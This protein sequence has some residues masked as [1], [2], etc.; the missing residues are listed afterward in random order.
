MIDEPDIALHMPYLE[1]VAFHSPFI[2]ELG[3][4]DG[5]GSTRAFQRGHERYGA[6]LGE[7][8]GRIHV[9]VELRADRPKCAYNSR[10]WWLLTG[11]SISPE[12]FT[13]LRIAYCMPADLIF[14]DTE[15]TYEHM[16][17][18]LAL[19]EIASGPQTVWLFHDTWMFGKYNRMTDT[20]IEFASKRGLVY[21]DLSTD[22]NGLGRMAHLEN[23]NLIPYFTSGDSG[24]AA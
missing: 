1:E 17:K 18:E 12:T 3:C 11:D 22:C 19:W 16:S 5:Y 6:K 20:I 2:I 14:I 4:G 9:S 15:H 23:A 10:Y 13:K 21:E 24:R 8:L 7:Q